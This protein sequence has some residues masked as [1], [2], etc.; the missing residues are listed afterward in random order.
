MWFVHERYATN[1]I[2]IY[3]IEQMLTC[4]QMVHIKHIINRKNNIIYGNPCPI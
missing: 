3:I 4:A 1:P 2:R